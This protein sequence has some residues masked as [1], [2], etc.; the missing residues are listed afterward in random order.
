MSDGVKC[1]A[2]LNVVSDG[3][4]SSPIRKNPEKHN[5]LAAH[6]MIVS[7]SWHPGH[8][9]AWILRRV[10]GV[11][12]KR[13]S[14]GDDFEVRLIPLSTILSLGMDARSGTGRPVAM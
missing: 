11:M 1:T 2:L 4:V 9:T 10:W 14:L 13:V 3:T 7:N 6:S 12:G 5:V 8:H